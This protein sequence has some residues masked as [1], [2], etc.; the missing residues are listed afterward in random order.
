M[1]EFQEAKLKNYGYSGGTPYYLI[2]NKKNAITYNISYDGNQ[3]MFTSNKHIYGLC[4]PSQPI[5]HQSLIAGVI[6][7]MA[8]C[9]NYS[10]MCS[11]NVSNDPTKYND[12][13]FR[14]P[15]PILGRNDT[16]IGAKTAIYVDY[17][18]NMVF[19]DN[20]EYEPIKD[21]IF[22]NSRSAAFEKW[23]RS[24]WLP[25]DVMEIVL[26][27][28]L[29]A[30][31]Y[32][33]KTTKDFFKQYLDSFRENEEI[34]EQLKCLKVKEQIDIPTKFIVYGVCN[35]FGDK[36]YGAL[37]SMLYIEHKIALSDYVKFKTLCNEKL[38]EL[39]KP[40]GKTYEYI[41]NMTKKQA[42]NEFKTYEDI[43]K[44]TRTCGHLKDPRGL[45]YSSY[46]YED[47]N[48]YYEEFG[49]S[50]WKGIRTYYPELYKG[51]R[52]ILDRYNQLK[53]AYIEKVNKMYDGKFDEIASQKYDII[54]NDKDDINNAF[55][56]II[57]KT[58]QIFSKLDSI[59]V[60][61]W[62]ELINIFTMINQDILDSISEVY[63]NEYKKR[64]LDYSYKHP[65][66][67][68]MEFVFNT[69]ILETGIHSHMF[70]ELFSFRPFI[71]LPITIKN[72]IDMPELANLKQALNNFDV[73]N[74]A[75]Y[76]FYVNGKK[77]KWRN[78]I[79]SER[80]YQIENIKD[81]LSNFE[82]KYSTKYY[83]GCGNYVGLAVSYD[84]NECILNSASN[85]NKITIND[86]EQ[87]IHAI[88]T[89]PFKLNF[90]WKP[91]EY[92]QRPILYEPTD[93]NDGQFSSEKWSYHS[94]KSFDTLL[95]E[96][97]INL[98]KIIDKMSFYITCE[99]ENEYIIKKNLLQVNCIKQNV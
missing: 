66:A 53:G 52:I 28:D 97:E 46:V 33:D 14:L 23:S 76:N 73:Y 21:Y 51:L 57:R 24:V 43:D 58:Q 95:N 80:V 7:I 37:V 48:E 39:L 12:P 91:N 67:K 94:G 54:L 11:N 90:S 77:L 82:F 18:N 3:F 98:E 10:V 68:K 8:Q 30:R 16:L 56:L 60:N 55:N 74:G 61:E 89:S 31:K 78:N 81:A 35:K 4:D 50:R 5:V 41:L 64:I 63:T 2:D 34:Q 87:T 25:K 13:M 79:N 19:D 86:L 26:Q 62:D 83:V 70:S 96:F 42:E 72:I 65:R 71:N 47:D 93:D 38:N 9:A 44:L 49:L 85:D 59:K 45:G 84:L 32:K 17:T 69:D 27:N 36:E 15:R 40:F 88:L 20:K 92:N 75:T 1:D 29:I 99:Y 22:P 6:Y